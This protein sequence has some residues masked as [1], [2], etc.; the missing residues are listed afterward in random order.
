MTFDRTKT[1]PGESRKEMSDETKRKTPP[2]KPNAAERLSTGW[3]WIIWTAAAVVAIGVFVGDWMWRHPAANTLDFELAKASLQAL[4]V[5]LIAGLVA[6]ATTRFTHIRQ[7]ITED[8]E[9]RHK[10]FERRA[11]ILDRA[12]Q[13]AQKMFA[14]CE[15]LRL[16]QVDRSPKRAKRKELAEA[17]ALLDKAYVD[18]YLDAEGLLLELGARYGNDESEQT[19]SGDKKIEQAEPRDEKSGPAE[20]KNPYKEW[21]KIEDLLIV[22]YFIL[23]GKPRR[24]MEQE[25]ASRELLPAGRLQLKKVKQL[26]GENEAKP[27]NRKDQELSAIRKEIRARYYVAISELTEAIFDG[28]FTAHFDV[29]RFFRVKQAIPPGS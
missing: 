11:A 2:G 20:P 3:L 5:G 18:F 9:K 6:I 24:A 25:T 23:C 28:E 17:R 26:Q 16:L 21:Q 8:A 14:S 15:H 22:Y 12:S 10:D 1:S 29:S 19:A 4:A 13:C 7:S 27:R